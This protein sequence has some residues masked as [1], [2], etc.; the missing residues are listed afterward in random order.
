MKKLTQ[1]Q[2]NRIAIAKD[3]IKW[4]TEKKFNIKIGSSYLTFKSKK[5]V[6][7]D[8]EFRDLVRNNTKSCQVCAKGALFICSVDKHDKLKLSEVLPQ[9]NL[10]VRKNLYFELFEDDVVSHVQDFDQEQLNLIEIAFEGRHDLD[11]DLWQMNQ[12]SYYLAAKFGKK[13][14]DAQGRL[15]AIMENVIKNKGEF[16]PY[17]SEEYKALSD[18]ADA[19][20]N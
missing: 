12:A 15:I 20:D 2:K 16:V 13:Y 18:F 7:Q 17:T 11:Y 3:V 5:Q 14:K 9:F 10:N 6:E 8:I 19:I 1:K 4:V